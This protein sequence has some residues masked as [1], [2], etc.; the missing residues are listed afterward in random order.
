MTILHI[1]YFFVI[2]S[3]MEGDRASEVHLTQWT[4]NAVILMMATYT[5]F[6]FGMLIVFVKKIITDLR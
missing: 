6:G 4:M 2:A 5:A 1:L 3:S